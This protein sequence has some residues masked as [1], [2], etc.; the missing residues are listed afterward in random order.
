MITV[1]RA[2]FLPILLSISV[3]IAGCTPPRDYEL[4]AAAGIDAQD[5]LVAFSEGAKRTTVDA[6]TQGLTAV[7]FDLRSRA[8]RQQAY[9]TRLAQIE[10]DLESWALMEAH[11]G[12]LRAY[13]TALRALATTDSPARTAG[14]IGGASSG[15]VAAGER[16]GLSLNIAGEASGVIQ[17]LARASL[18]IA[19]RAALAE[20]LERRA[21]LISEQID[22]Q[23]KAI[24]LLAARFER[25]FA[26]AAADRMGAVETAVLSGR[27]GDVER[28]QVAE[29]LRDSVLEP[30]AAALQAAVQAAR[31]S[32]D[33]MAALWDG[34]IRRAAGDVSFETLV[35]RAQDLAAEAGQLKTTAGVIWGAI[36]S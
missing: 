3:A 4:A 8:E 17:E 31:D 20:E 29:I 26:S 15:L 10:S 6:R 25:D 18:T 5:A 30:D 12:Q 1:S 33:K 28:V 11:A 32:A 23:R 22:L 24:G 7:L 35:D 36:G 27:V 34:L 21:T 13:F 2:W 9:E 14:A 19:Q 16:L